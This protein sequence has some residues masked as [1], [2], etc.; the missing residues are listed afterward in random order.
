M[1]ED[2]MEYQI[3]RMKNGKQQHFNIDTEKWEFSDDRWSG[4]F[5]LPEREAFQYFA[6]AEKKSRK[7]S[8]TTSPR[9]HQVI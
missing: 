5:K 8:T 6:K 9:I 1:I 4:E 2:L 3:I 7:T